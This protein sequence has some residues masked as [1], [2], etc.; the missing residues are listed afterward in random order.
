M[1]RKKEKW[2]DGRTEILRGKK[3]P[4]EDSKITCFHSRERIQTFPVIPQAS[5]R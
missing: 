5:V 3:I 4:D 2:K 1:K